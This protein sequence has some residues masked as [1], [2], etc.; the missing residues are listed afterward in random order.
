[1]PGLPEQIYCAEQ[2]SIPPTFPYLLRQ[3]AKAAIRSQPTD[4]LQWST[5]YFRCLSLNIPPPVK[6]RL[7]YPIPRDHYGITPGWLKALLYQLSS[8]KT[9]NFKILWDRWIGACLSH[10][11]LIQILCL[12]G[13]DNPKEIPWLRF[14]GLC[15]AHLTDD[16]TSSMKL[17][18]EI[19]TDEPEGGS[20]MIPL[21]TFMDLY[22]FLAKIDASKGQ[23]LKNIYFTDSLLSLYREISEKEVK[24]EVKEE[25]VLEE[26]SE[27]SQLSEKSESEEVEKEMSKEEISCPSLVGDDQYSVDYYIDHVAV[28]EEHDEAEEG[29]TGA[30]E[31]PAYLK[32]PSGGEMGEVD[33]ISPELMYAQRMFEMEG[34]GEFQEDALYDIIAGKDVKAKLEGSEEPCPQES[35]DTII[36]EPRKIV[37]Y[38]FEDEK[39]LLE[40]LERLKALQQEI[41]GEADE[42]IEKFKCR[43][44]AEMPLTDSQNLAIEQFK[45]K[46][47]ED[48]LDEVE[49]EE[50]KSEEE[51]VEKEDYEEI[52]VDK[53]PGI[54]PVVPDSLIN[55][56]EEYMKDVAAIQ[57]NMVMPRNIRHYNCP[58]LELVEA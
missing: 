17:I 41:P 30:I 5:A 20:A 38:D 34:E 29:S 44:I 26:E 45:E 53:V 31:L 32:E 54:G 28:G 9:I 18:C 46:E 3:Y 11:T 27:K 37:P 36:E 43:L 35:V 57:H 12:G 50:E 51:Q 16:L 2:I 14:I 6:P 10:H 22:T 40:D 52:W 58:P 21:A 47:I 25:V 42:E 23:M 39:T 19:M 7:E 4:L 56:V 55:A 1:M 24:E 49:A 33:D 48:K 8:N 15:A 13:F